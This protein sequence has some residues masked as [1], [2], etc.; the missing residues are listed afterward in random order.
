[1][2]APARLPVSR[3]LAVVAGAAALL[4]LGAAALL[5]TGLGGG[6]PEELLIGGVF[7]LS[8]GTSV[9]TCEQALAGAWLL[10]SG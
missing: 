10:W 9:E 6:E 4:V 7:S 2:A 1:M 8:S 5:I 3:T